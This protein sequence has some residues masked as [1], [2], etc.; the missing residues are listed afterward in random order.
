M[1]A[2]THRLNGSVLPTVLML[3]SILSLLAVNTLRTATV[4]AQLTDSL[5]LAGR[6]FESAELGIAAGMRF[7]INNPARLANELPLSL[8]VSDPAANND[9]E[10]TL[11]HTA[12]DNYCSEMHEKPV[13][14]IH[15][16][17]RSE[18][19]LG[20]LRRSHV[21]G[22]YICRNICAAWCTGIETPPVKSYWTVRDL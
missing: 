2:T 15:Y 8:R 14:R 20:A 10:V 4:E 7:A 16:E 21:Q 11:I 12:V 22:F 5:L 18:V 3:L 1:P 6:A 13:E 17:I 19:A 9:I